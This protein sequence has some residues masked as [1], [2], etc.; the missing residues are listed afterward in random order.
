MSGFNPFA[1][2]STVISIGG[3]SFENRLDAV[4]IDGNVS[5]GLDRAGLETAKKILAIIAKTVERLEN[6][7]NLP[8]ELSSEPD[9]VTGTRNPF[10]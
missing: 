7:D 8:I 9:A 5:I 10:V 2:E 4:I 6:S 1:D 3:L